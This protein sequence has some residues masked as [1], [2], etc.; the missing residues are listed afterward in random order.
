MSMARVVITAV[1]VEHRTISEVARDYKVSRRW[2]HELVRRFDAE[3]EAAFTPRSRRPHHSPHAVPADL[4]DQIVRLC[5]KLHGQGLDAGAET[6]RAML[7]A[8]TSES[9]QSL[10]VPTTPVTL[11]DLRVFMD[12]A[13]EALPP[14]DTRWAVDGGR[15]ERVDTVGTSLSE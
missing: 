9:G 8:R 4:E 14:D 3:G 7:A 15:F 5:K 6:I 13:T 1:R 11:C 10:C 2:V 12:E